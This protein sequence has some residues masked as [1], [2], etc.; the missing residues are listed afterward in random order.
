MAH[1]TLFYTKFNN[2][3]QQAI[4]DNWSKIKYVIPNINIADMQNLT[5]NEINVLLERA[6]EEKMKENERKNKQYEELMEKEG[7]NK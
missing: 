5:L 4:L 2:D 1:P 6:L 7:G 3:I